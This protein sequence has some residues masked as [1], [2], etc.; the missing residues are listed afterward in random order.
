M[1]IIGTLGRAGVS[2]ANSF[3]V[4]YTG[5]WALHLAAVTGKDFYD[6]SG[7]LEKIADRSKQARES[8]IDTFSAHTNSTQKGDNADTG[9]SRWSM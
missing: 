1:Q 7:H 4:L 5:L 3:A 2:L 8:F 9:K 6:V